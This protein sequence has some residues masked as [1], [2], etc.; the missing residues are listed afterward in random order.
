VSLAARTM[1]FDRRLRNLPGPAAPAS[2]PVG[3]QPFL[4]EVFG[5]QARILVEAAFGAD[6][7]TEPQTW[8]FFDITAD[9]ML[10]QGVTISPMGRS[11]EFSTS[12]PAGCGF[13]LIN[14][15]G[16]YTA[17]NP[18]SRYSPYVR[19]NTPI[20]VSLFL[21]G[22]NA[23]Q[24]L[25]F[26]GGA[27]GWVPSWDTSAQLA[28]V[29]VSASGVLRR[30]MQ[31]K[32]PLLSAARRAMILGGPLAGWTLDDGADATQFGSVLVGGAAL[33]GTM[34]TPAAVDSGMGGAPGK[35]PQLVAS[36]AYTGAAV[37][38]LGGVS[39]TGWSMQAWVKLT[40]DE[41]P[42]GTPEATVLFW[43]ASGLLYLWL[44]QVD[45]QSDGD[46]ITVT[47][48]RSD[49][50]AAATVLIASG[51]STGGWHHL[52]VTAR[53]TTA[54]VV[55]AELLVD[56]VSAAVAS[57]GSVPFPHSIGT[58]LKVQVGNDVVD[59]VY[60]FT[61]S[62]VAGL[63]V[64]QLAF[65]DSADAGS[66][67]EAGLGY[68]GETAA[69][70]LL[71]L[72]S[73]NNLPVTVVGD[74]DDTKAMGPQ[75]ADT[76][77][78]TLRECEAADGGVLYD[79][80]SAGVT[81]VT[82]SS[83]YNVAATLTADMAA[84]PPQLAVPFTPTDDDQRNRNLVVATR[85]NGSS[86]TFED[87]DGPL[88]TA[89]IGTYDSSMTVNVED[90]TDLVNQAGWQVHQGAVEGFRYPNLGLDLAAAPAI[91]TDW[92]RTQVSARV[93]AVNVTSKATQHPPNDV[94]QIVE[95]WAETLSPFVWLANLN[96][97]PYA[98]W[99]VFEVEGDDN[100]GRLELT[101][102][103][104]VAVDTDDTTWSV[105]TPGSD[106]LLTTSGAFPADFPYDINVGGERVTVTD[107]S[108]GSSPQTVTV[109][110]SVNGVVAEHPAGT[111]ITLWVPGVVAL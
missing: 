20:R 88:G 39:T 96:C 34:P 65:F 49:V 86:A 85:K 77:T 24:A 103:L 8:N 41:T 42:V 104:A 91:A 12:Q 95:G 61:P 26:Q 106:P 59:N 58:L 6:L 78:N 11:D 52:H 17:Y 82:R 15:S 64:A 44:V 67:Y 87:A 108:G 75:S 80:L 110:R 9:V 46:R 63:S 13:T 21:T 94:Q 66:L 45:H 2:S 16:D 33:T 79:G 23:D 102:T 54:S 97:S 76:L 22:T 73:E 25:R 72:G 14:T 43:L 74:P 35:F 109:T 53:Q 47:P 83:R 105:A 4:V 70:R 101:Q 55:D 3:G 10:A 69:R 99:E 37:A 60:V 18:A 51:L 1:A 84:D 19:R 28:I 100:R 89:A 36:H 31:G 68:P 90:D 27:N 111:P 107:T 81:Y 5:Q 92:L 56:G 71:R 62:D 57:L 29:T 40:S 38:H 50:G 32:T 7:T 48:W 98:P 93:D 30:L